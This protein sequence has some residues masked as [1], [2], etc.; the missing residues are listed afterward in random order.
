MAH[1]PFL[2]WD[3]FEYRDVQDENGVDL[4]LIR[5]NLS[6]SVSERIAEHQKA[7]ASIEWFREATRNGR[8]KSNNRSA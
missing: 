8:A 4:E 3:G 2:A 5:H 7:A 6:L 1:K